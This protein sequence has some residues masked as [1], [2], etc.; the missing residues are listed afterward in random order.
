[1]GFSLSAYF[2]LGLTGLWMW[3]QRRSQQ[4]RPDWLRPLHL[5]LGSGLVALVLLLLSVGIVGTIGHYG[6]LGH[7][8][9]LPAGLGVVALVCVSAISASQISRQRSWARPVHVTT[10]L[11]LLIGFSWVSWTGWGVVQKYLP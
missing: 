8:W 5:G 10:N 4:P 11:L 1:M 9:H 7:S 2:L 3:M 6:T